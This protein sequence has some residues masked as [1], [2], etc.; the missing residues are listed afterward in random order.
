MGKNNETE[1]LLLH[2]HAYTTT[3]TGMVYKYATE[4]DAR[5]LSMF[6]GESST[7]GSAFRDDGFPHLRAS[8]LSRLLR[9][10]HHKRGETSFDSRST[11]ERN[12]T[13]LGRV[14]WEALKTGEM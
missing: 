13:E 8:L 1:A 6:T 4:G 9:P 3:E 5:P 14:H 10:I 7:T 11:A 12:G 2:A